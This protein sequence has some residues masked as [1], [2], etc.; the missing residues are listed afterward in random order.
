LKNISGDIKV[1]YLVWA[2]HNPYEIGKTG[3]PA[4]LPLLGGR[5]SIRL[6]YSD[7]PCPS[8]LIKDQIG[9]PSRLAGDGRLQSAGDES[10]EISE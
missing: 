8:S 6:S 10:L 7:R 2:H 4:I 1:K 3:D 9:R 5:E